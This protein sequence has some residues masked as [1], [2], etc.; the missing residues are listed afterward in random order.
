[1]IRLLLQLA[2]IVTGAES[3]QPL[4]FSIVTLQ[5]NGG[6]QFTDAS[7]AFAFADAKAG[8]YVLSVRQIG[9]MPRDT[10]LVLT[11]GAVTLHIA[12]HRLAIELPPVTVTAPRCTNPGAPDSSNA[13]LF[14]VFNQ[15]QENA[16]RADL[17]ADSFPYE[18][19]LELSVREISQR[20]DTTGP[21]LNQIHF[22]SHHDHPYRP[23]RVVEPAWGPWGNSDS[24]VLIHTAELRDLGN[25][26]FVANHCFSLAGRD[27]IG[28]ETLVRVN[29]DPAERIR[30][31]DMAGAA[32]L[33]TGTYELRY[34]M[35]LL[36][37]PERSSVRDVR[38]LLT[39]THFRDIAPGVPLQDSSVGVTTYRYGSLAERIEVQRTLNVRFRRQPPS[40]TPPAPP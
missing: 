36:T 27:T 22:S 13:A 35:T 19:D 14:A 39:R 9:Y 37:K 23:G 31:A 17:L 16:R 20:G 6:R 21:M 33:D 28:G 11:E 25:P 32:Y 4:G 5:P 12:L 3:G 1:M 29:F 40:Q 7:G 26:I 24:V 10:Q 30:S 34:T 18:Y 2:G 8:K 15:V 38:T